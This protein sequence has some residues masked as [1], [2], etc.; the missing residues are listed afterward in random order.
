MADEWAN[1]NLQKRTPDDTCA[2]CR[3]K[4][5]PGERL[6][7]AYILLA[8]NVPNPENVAQ[9]SLELGADLEFCHV[10][11]SDPYLRGRRVEVES[12]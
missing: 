5:K 12:T 3:R 8:S 10:R 1:P 2:A 4:F 9:R 6:M 11:C 7:P